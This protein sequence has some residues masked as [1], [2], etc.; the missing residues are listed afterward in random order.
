MSTRRIPPVSITPAISGCNP[1]VAVGPGMNKTGL[2][3]RTPNPGRFFEVMPLS[4]ALARVYKTEACMVLYVAPDATRQ[5]RINK[6]GLPLWKGPTP[7]VHAVGCDID[8]MPEHAPWTRDA[9]ERAR[10]QDQTWPIFSTAGVYYTPAG[11]RVIQPLA[12]PMRVT[13]VEPYTMAWIAKLLALGLA[14]DTSCKDWTRHFRL[15]HITRKNEVGL[16]WIVRSPCI[17]LSRMR[18]I[19]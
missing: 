19:E 6:V 17:D 11:R 5:P 13:E 14:A 4:E 1:P 12:R 2:K 15:P 18:A 10:D 3:P 9:Y 7:L 8:D 16:D